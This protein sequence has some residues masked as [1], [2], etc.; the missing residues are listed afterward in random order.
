MSIE[1]KI[2]TRKEAVE[3]GLKRY[4]TGKP[5]KHGHVSE[6]AVV[7]HT[8]LECITV[9]SRTPRRRIRAKELKQTLAYKNVRKKRTE[10]NWEYIQRR[11]RVYRIKNKERLYLTEV[12]RRYN[13]TKEEYLYL[14]D[15]N[16]SRCH[17]CNQKP[18]G[19]RLSVDHDH[20]CCSGPTSCGKCVRGLLCENCNRGL[21]SFKDS[22]ENF[23]KAISYLEK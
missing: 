14:L 15:K 12:K 20:S 10:E 8:C 21:G 17:I 6:R 23:N 4:F 3:R 19:K 2:I 13:L 1:P 7:N 16:D 5:C 18:K 9:K 11:N 22:V